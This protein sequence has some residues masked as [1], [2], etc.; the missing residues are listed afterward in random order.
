VNSRFAV[1]AIFVAR[2]PAG[3]YGVSTFWTVD[4]SPRS[5]IPFDLLIIRL[6]QI[7]DLDRPYALLLG[8][9]LLIQLWIPTRNARF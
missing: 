1:D 6:M 8:L 5:S 3:S 4:K 7:L 2:L 9:V